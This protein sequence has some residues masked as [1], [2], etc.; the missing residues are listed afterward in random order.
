[1]SLVQA[2]KS[3][4]ERSEIKPNTR[5]SQEKD[6]WTRFTSPQL[7]KGSLYWHFSRWFTLHFWQFVGW[8]GGLS[9]SWTIL[10][11]SLKMFQQRPRMETRIIKNTLSFSCYQEKTKAIC[12]TKEAFLFSSGSHTKAALSDTPTE[13]MM[14]KGTWCPWLSFDFSFQFL[15]LKFFD[16]HNFSF[17]C[18][19][20]S[21]ILT[22][23]SH[24]YK[25]SLMR[26]FEHLLWLYLLDLLI[27]YV[28]I[29]INDL[30]VVEGNWKYSWHNNC[31]KDG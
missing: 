2:A 16:I 1:M 17:L 4:H 28:S 18:T 13:E 31:N 6:L 25:Q 11:M 27:L 5:M 9:C 21:Y 30:T 29:K 10:E 22:E 14:S 26:L 7:I 3:S 8:V 20:G 23:M 15:S 24:S 19:R 12:A